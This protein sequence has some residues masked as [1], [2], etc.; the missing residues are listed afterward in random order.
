M[1]RKNKKKIRG[2]GTIPKSEKTGLEKAE[3]FID[4]AIEV[5]QSRA[6]SA[7][8]KQKQYGG[9]DNV[10]KNKNAGFM[11]F[12]FAD[13]ERWAG[14]AG[15]KPA[16]GADTRELDRWLINF[17]AHE[18]HLRGV[19]N[20]ATSIISSRSFT[21]TGGRNG[22]VR[23]KN[24]LDDANRNAG[25]RKGEG[26]KSYIKNMSFSYYST[27]MGAINENGRSGD[28]LFANG[29]EFAQ[30]LSAIWSADPTK[31]KL[32]GDNEFPLQYSPR[33]GSTQKWRHA[34]YF[35]VAQ[36]R[37]VI[38]EQLGIGYPAVLMCIELAQI[39][40][41]IYKHDKEQLGAIA[42]KGLLLL[43]GVTKEDWNQAMQRRKKD[44]EEMHREYYG[45]I[46][47]L[48]S[49]PMTEIDAKLIA[50][51]QL[52]VGFDRRQ[53]IDLLM[54]L[55]ALCFGY[56]PEEFWVVKAA[57]FQSRSAEVQLGMERAKS[58]GESVF[59][60]EFRDKLQAELPASVLFS[61]D[62]RDQR[63]DKLNAETHKI[64]AEI[65]TML[66]ESG[67]AQSAP[68][69]SKQRTLEYLVRH[70]VLP[71]E[72]SEVVEDAYATD[73]EEAGRVRMRKWCLE[74]KRTWLAGERTPDQPFVCYRW[75]PLLP[76]GSEIVLW[77]RC[78]D[79]FR[80]K[81]WQ[82]GRNFSRDKINDILLSAG[83]R[84]L[85]RD[86]DENVEVIQVAG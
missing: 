65:A 33:S 54:Y 57:A 58:K 53:F 43:N 7:T 59:L 41:A 56:P 30:P 15:K 62:E 20:T 24:I 60:D 61:Y 32:T 5:G 1:A 77:D 69:L 4:K 25:A 51:S 68:L 26:Y 70:R 76:E 55:Y 28:V 37:S 79:I 44:L 9:T 46:A 39:M 6:T 42:P 74:Q 75:D 48:A 23:A 84:L 12:S 72:F 31:F 3:E 14:K 80:P 35:R 45:G 17:L 13:V 34:D 16:Y 22:V 49:E 85:P 78:D 27:C 86:Y 66:Y 82:V 2:R 8:S 19:L 21:M 63:G 40:V 11:P 29:M 52:P 50:L 83:K 67:L 64:Y 71:P 36:N 73:V 38:E 81:L 47:V 10:D 18:S